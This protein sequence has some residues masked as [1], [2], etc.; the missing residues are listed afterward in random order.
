MIYY[1][2]ENAKIIKI[3]TKMDADFGFSRN[4]IGFIFW[5]FLPSENALAKKHHF[6]GNDGNAYPN[7]DGISSR[8][9]KING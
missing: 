6:T 9:I 5:L 3:F 2:L 4:F 1:A 8:R 7:N